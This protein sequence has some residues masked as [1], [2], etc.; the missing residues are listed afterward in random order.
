MS[1]TYD[2]EN[3]RWIALGCHSLLLGF[4]LL[5]GLIYT[6][7]WIAF[8]GIYPVVL[9][10]MVRKV[11]VD[12]REENLLL[13]HNASMVGLK[14]M[15]KGKAFNLVFKTSPNDLARL[16]TLAAGVEEVKFKKARQYTFTLW[17]VLLNIG[18][19]ALA[20]KMGLHIR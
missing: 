10:V 20:I 15:R 16:K 13:D 2:P 7:S 11:N 8:F 19:I 4:Q 12:L 5:K 17:F 14:K 9:L 3:T 18:A 1:F 6:Q